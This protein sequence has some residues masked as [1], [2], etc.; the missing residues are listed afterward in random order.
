MNRTP[1]V[2]QYDIMSNRWGDFKGKG[3]TEQAIHAGIQETGRGNHAEGKAEQPRSSETV[4][5]QEP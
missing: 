5:D 2:G 3:S 1:F 4:R